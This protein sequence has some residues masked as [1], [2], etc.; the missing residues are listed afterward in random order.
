MSRI[1][2][3]E[4]V[5]E[6]ID[7]YKD[8]E[9]PLIMILH[10]IQ[11]QYGYLSYEVV[12]YLANSIH[13]SI[14]EIYGVITFYDDF[15]ITPIGKYHINVC[16]GTVCYIKG[17]QSIVD[18]IYKLLKIKDG[19]CTPDFKF[20]LDTSRCLGCCSMAPVMA[21]NGRIYGNLKIKDI[22]NIF[23]EYK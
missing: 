16:L 18:E 9:N 23:D 2:N 17:S 1:N 14:N 11:E 6:I 7:K 20:S 8:M 13:F 21:I 5:K 4:K 19:E 10:E 12:S 22:K 15:R 3:L